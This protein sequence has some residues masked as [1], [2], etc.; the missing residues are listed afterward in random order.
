MD[1]RTGLVADQTARSERISELIAPHQLT[2]E[3]VV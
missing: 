2:L 3:K 1:A